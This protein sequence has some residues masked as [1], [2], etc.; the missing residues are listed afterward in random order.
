MAV[1]NGTA[2]RDV[3]NGTS[4]A[5]TARGNG[6]DD[7]L[8]GLGGNDA[9]YGD[10][11]NDGLY[12]GTGN[13]RLWGG[14]GID[15]LF[16]QDGA[17]QIYGEAGDDWLQGGAGNDYLHGGSGND[18][19]RGDDG[20]DILNGAAGDNDLRGGAGNDTLI[21]SGL[22]TGGR[23]GG[24]AFYD[25]GAGR[26]TLLVD[27]R[28]DYLVDG[29]DVASWVEL[30][31]NAGGLGTIMYAVDPL[32]GSFQAVGQF[33]GIEEFRVTAESSRL[34]VT[35]RSDATVVGGNGG[36][37]LEGR[38]GDQD[39]TGGA[40][41][42]NYQFLWRPNFEANHDVIHGFSVAE[43]D[44]IS[45]NNQYEGDLVSVPDPLVI[46]PVEVDGHTIYTAVEV[47]TGKV[48]HTLDVDAVGLPPPEPWYFLG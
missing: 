6:G 19:L 24:N 2:T 18:R 38:Q 13:D 47:A 21:H 35:A 42:D 34:S 23:P 45:Y 33:A 44:W 27:Y 22:I 12:G 48:V 3:Y 20:G 15:A 26:D 28:G 39:F 36:D 41:A 11:G 14:A 1:F 5:D 29:L 9:L 43:G 32:E 16:G 46:T 31:I 30:N 7:T 25:G 40:G 4:S 17:D 10:S 37:K 8:N